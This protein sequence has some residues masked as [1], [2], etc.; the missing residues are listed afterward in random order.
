MNSGHDSRRARQ[1][2]TQRI[3]RG[4]SSPQWNREA[5][6]QHEQFQRRHGSP[7]EGPYGGQYGGH[8]N[9]R[10]SRHGQ[11]GGYG[12]GDRTRNKQQG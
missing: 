3:G 10:E 6:M 2:G 8:E 7:Y 1:D 5:Q 4:A 11:Q 12:H 9:G